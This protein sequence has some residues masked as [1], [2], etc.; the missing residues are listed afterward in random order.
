MFS[1][2]LHQQWK[3]TGLALLGILFHLSIVHNSLKRIRRV[4][5]FLIVPWILAASLNSHNKRM[6]LKRDEMRADI[7]QAAKIPTG[8]F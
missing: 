4:P 6:S 2:I 1:A 8:A 5:G 7:I 3:N